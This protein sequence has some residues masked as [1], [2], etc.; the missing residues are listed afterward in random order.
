MTDEHSK[1]GG[2]RRVGAK[3]RKSKLDKPTLEF[4][5]LA[6]NP[7]SKQPPARPDDNA[8]PLPPDLPGLP[9]LPDDLSDEALM[10]VLQAASAPAREA[11]SPKDLPAPAS[12]DALL[13]AIEYDTKRLR[14]VT[15]QEQAAYAARQQ[16]AGKAAPRPRPV[17]PEDVPAPAN[18]G[19]RVTA[20]LLTVFFTLGTCGMV[21]AFVTIW[22]NPFSAINPLP[23]LT[24]VPIVVSQT[25]TPSDTPQ[26][27]ATPTATLPPSATPSPAPTAAPT[28]TPEPGTPVPAF[29]FSV[30]RTLGSNQV[31]ITN[32]DQRGGCAWSSIGGNVTDEN[33]DALDDYQ[34]RV[35]GD[36]LN[37]TLISG[38]S[39]AYGEGGFELQLGF[40]ARDAQFALQL[41]DP[42]GT[43]VSDV[44]PITTS[45]RCDWNISVVRFVRDAE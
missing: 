21:A 43:P 45:S 28:D 6:P 34:I 41:F 32:P 42:N 39:T 17:R 7:N 29:S 26:P 5:A 31:Y 30:P 44:I 27:S 18:S 22:N 20:N 33:G 14:A 36:D 2:V 24:P 10:A 3:D 23:P 1:S 40:E 19:R 11:E 9:E 38:T 25:P 15:P 8:P 13:D 37:E 16:S 4:G 12:D 35:L